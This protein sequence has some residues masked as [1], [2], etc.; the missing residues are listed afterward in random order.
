MQAEAQNNLSKTDDLRIAERVKYNISVAYSFD[1]FPRPDQP[2]APYRWGNLL[3]ISERGICF[4]ATDH[5]FV[6][7]LLSLQL[8]LTDQTGGIRM[9]GKITWAKTEKDGSTRV[10]VQFIGM[11]PSD[12]RKLIGE[13]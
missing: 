7:R 3:D 6:Q 4:E 10:G 5:F 12:W 2:S 9:L 13:K 1:A 8:K 11:L